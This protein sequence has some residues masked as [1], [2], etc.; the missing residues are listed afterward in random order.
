MIVAMSLKLVLLNAATMACASGSINNGTNMMLRGATSV[1]GQVVVNRTHLQSLG[2]IAV[3]P[4]DL[5]SCQINSPAQ[6][7]LEYSFEPDSDEP[8][9]T[10]NKKKIFDFSSTGD[11]HMDP[12]SMDSAQIEEIVAE[13]VYDT[14]S[15]ISSNVGIDGSYGAYTAATSLSTENLNQRHVKTVRIDKRIKAS[16]YRVTMTTPYPHQKLKPGWKNFLLSEPP[17]KIMRTMG[18]FFARQLDMGG[19]L[20]LTFVVEQH[21]GETKSSISAD[22]DA[23]YLDVLSASAEGAVKRDTFKS[24]SMMTS[25][26]NAWG[27]KGFSW[28][29]LTNSNTDDIQKKWAASV[30][31]SNLHAIKYQLR[32]LWELLDH[33]DMN[34]NKAIEL[35]SY[36]LQ[37]WSADIANIPSHQ[38]LPKPPK[39]IGRITIKQPSE[40]RGWYDER[41][42]SKP[43]CD[44]ITKSENGQKEGCWSV[45]E[46]YCP[47]NTRCLKWG[48][49]CYAG[50]IDL[51]AGVRVEMYK[52]YGW[53]WNDAC[54]GTSWRSFEG[55]D[56]VDFWNYHERVCAFKFSLAEGYTCE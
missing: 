6:R 20:Q 28:L 8:L 13:S 11:C 43:A 24:N 12:I 44:F 51:P 1:L 19:V 40:E 47:D 41:S 36:M 38:Y 54:A 46:L 21:E 31:D 7:L 16:K 35:R 39:V 17:E 48:P 25:K 15:Q 30:D 9:F 49:H 50:R 23:K 5:Q 2:Q 18:S 33:A 29:G 14:A 3:N 45:D 4:D 56:S 53:W 27:G 55:K 22:V 26:W 10:R 52:L 34:P 42:T 32:P 37:K